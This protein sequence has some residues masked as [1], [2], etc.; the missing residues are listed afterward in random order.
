MEEKGS[1][2]K[3]K[4]LSVSSFEW[5]RKR[6]NWINQWLAARVLVNSIAM[7]LE[8]IQIAPEGKEQ[9]ECKCRRQWGCYQWEWN[10]NCHV[11][12]GNWC[13]CFNFHSHD[14]FD[15][16]HGS[17]PFTQKTNSYHSLT[18]SHRCTATKM[19]SPIY[20]NFDIE[21]RNRKSVVKCKHCSVQLTYN[22]K[23]S[24]NLITHLKVCVTWKQIIC[25][26]CNEFLFLFITWRNSI[27]RSCPFLVSIRNHETILN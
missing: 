17:W 27:Q 18:S 20:H 22:P 6:K 15:F 5:D 23:V 8:T 11:G 13:K 14:N 24:S 7:A 16:F 12:N 2:W 25:M 9:T 3:R 1:R 21:D 4:W 26:S 19:P 10:G